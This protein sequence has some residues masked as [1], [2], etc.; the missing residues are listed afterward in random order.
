VRELERWL[1]PLPLVVPPLAERRDEIP[2]LVDVL[3]AN[4]ARREAL[5]PAVFE[6]EA[7]A[8]LWRQ[9]WRGGV[10]ALS[11]LVAQL[12]RAHPGER[13][14][15]REVRAALRSRHLALRVRLSSRRPGLLALEQA[16]EVTAHRVGSE[17]H[18]RAARYLGW[19]PDTLVAR[20][21]ELRR[22]REEGRRPCP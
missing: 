1:D 20:L 14:G 19:D 22:A 8:D 17:N 9:D 18:A 4:V 2:A 10:A 11:A 15:G 3:A 13:I 21:A 5:A 7:I 12:V 6:D 16:L